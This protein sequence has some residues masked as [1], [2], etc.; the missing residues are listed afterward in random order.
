M[1][2]FELKVQARQL[3]NVKIGGIEQIFLQSRLLATVAA[4][5]LLGYGLG[6]V[7][8]YRDLLK[9]SLSDDDA[10]V[11]RKELSTDI[12]ST[13]LRAEEMKKMHSRIEE[14]LEMAGA[15][16]QKTAEEVTGVIQGFLGESD[17]ITGRN[18]LSQSFIK[19]LAG[20]S[21]SGDHE[22]LANL[23]VA[24]GNGKK[25]DWRG[26]VLALV[27]ST[28]SQ[29]PSAVEE[30]CSLFIDDGFLVSSFLSEIS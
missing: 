23:I 18:V 7:R 19:L 20:S 27:D 8:T 14:V 25:L 17:P 28:E 11:Q 24:Y 4:P 12:F 3:S 22:R 13:E 5:A 30:L 10:P 2:F 15:A 26:G 16:Q 9:F 6:A 21:E 29:E 1:E